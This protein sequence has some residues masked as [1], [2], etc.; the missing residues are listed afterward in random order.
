MTNSIAATPLSYALY[1]VRNDQ[2]CVLL[3]PTRPLA[4]AIALLDPLWRPLVS[5]VDAHLLSS[6]VR[7]P[8][9]MLVTRALVILPLVCNVSADCAWLLLAVAAGT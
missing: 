9:G 5:G 6:L 2:L 7:S 1:V 8:L 3:D 4:G